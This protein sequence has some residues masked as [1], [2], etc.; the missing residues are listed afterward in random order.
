MID[1]LARVSLRSTPRR[2]DLL[3]AAAMKSMPERSVLKN[4]NTIRVAK[5][6]VRMPA[7]RLSRRNPRTPIAAH[8]RPSYIFRRVIFQPRVLNLA[9]R[10]PGHAASA[11]RRAPAA[12]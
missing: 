7:V 3:N 11:V 1:R 10:A 2:G 5:A 12:P 6:Q 4:A 8:A 9:L